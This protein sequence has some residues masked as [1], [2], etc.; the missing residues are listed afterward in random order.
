MSLQTKMYKMSNRIYIELN[1]C[2]Y[3]EQQNSVYL[4]EVTMVRRLQLKN[5]FKDLMTTVQKLHK[6]SNYYSWNYK[7]EVSWF[8][9][10]SLVDDIQLK[11]HSPPQYFN[12]V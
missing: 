2:M 12:A 10:F 1:K 6:F 7:N 5:R 9:G 8:I 11:H 3:I 4:V